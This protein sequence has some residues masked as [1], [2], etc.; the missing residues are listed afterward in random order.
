VKVLATAPLFDQNALEDEADRAS[1][2]GDEFVETL[3]VGAASAG[4]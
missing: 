4:V 1:G 3:L 2:F